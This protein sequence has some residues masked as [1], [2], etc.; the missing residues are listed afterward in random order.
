LALAV[1]TESNL[2]EVVLWRQI[3]PCA[4]DSDIREMLGPIEEVLS[5]IGVTSTEVAH[6]LAIDVKAEGLGVFE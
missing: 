1:L 2:E 4:P 3:V 5:P 6:D